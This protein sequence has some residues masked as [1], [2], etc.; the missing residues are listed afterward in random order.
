MGCWCLDSA[1]FVAKFFCSVL[2]S[3][4]VSIVTLHGRCSFDLSGII[5]SSCT[6]RDTSRTLQY[7]KVDV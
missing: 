6:I 4:Y 1:D 2:Y 3:L 7:L 5:G